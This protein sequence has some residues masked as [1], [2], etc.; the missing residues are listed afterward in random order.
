MPGAVKNKNVKT[1]R[2]REGK[3]ESEKG[4]EIA[5]TKRNRGF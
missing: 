1:H 3:R 5:K 2:Q 4:G